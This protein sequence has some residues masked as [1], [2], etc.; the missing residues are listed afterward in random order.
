MLGYCGSAR[1]IEHETSRTHPERPDR[2]R[3]IE[4]AVRQAGLVGS[5]NPFPDFEYDSQLKP[6]GGPALLNWIF[7]QPMKNGCIRCIRANTLNG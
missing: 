4:T 2:I 5:P 6:V 3:A 7:R 1:F